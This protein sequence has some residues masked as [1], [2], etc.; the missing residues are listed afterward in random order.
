M[1][2]KVLGVR[3]QWAKTHPELAPS[4]WCARSS[5]P[6]KFVKDPAN[7]STAA[8][9]AL[10]LGSMCRR[11]LIARTLAGELKVATEGTLRGDHRYLMIGGHAD[12]PD[13][14]QA[15]WLYAQMARAGARRHYR[16]TRASPRKRCSGPT[17]TTP[18]SAKLRTLR[19]ANRAMVSAHSSVRTSARSMS[20]V[21]SRPG[22]P[23]ARVGRACPSCAK[24]VQ[25]TS[26]SQ[27][28]YN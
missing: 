23:S 28:T 11:R 21:T 9:S 10:V 3:E 1:S 8:A 6:D 15:A 26:Y 18:R 19:A 7:R 16:K 2:E 24:F 17:A 20:P 14:V 4:H 5:T 22:A 27:S 12:R 13:P 25:C